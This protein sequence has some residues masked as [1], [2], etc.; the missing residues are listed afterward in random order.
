MGSWHAPRTTWAQLLPSNQCPQGDRYVSSKPC[1]HGP[2]WV[3]I[4]A[5]L[6]LGLTPQGHTFYVPARPG[7]PAA[8]LPSGQRKRTW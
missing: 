3:D 4:Q 5:L 2:T 8:P 1:P 6:S 7:P